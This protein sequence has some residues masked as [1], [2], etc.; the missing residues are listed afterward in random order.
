MWALVVLAIYLTPFFLLDWA[1]DAAMKRYA[2]D[3]VQSQAGA[4]RTPRKV[5][6]ALAL[7][8][9]GLPLAAWTLSNSLKPIESII[10]EL[11]PEVLEAIRRQFGI[12]PR[13][14]STTISPFAPSQRSWSPLKIPNRLR[15]LH[16]DYQDTKK[17]FL[18]MIG[19]VFEHP[20]NFPI[21]GRRQHLRVARPLLSSEPFRPI[22][23]GSLGRVRTQIGSR[24]SSHP[25]GWSKGRHSRLL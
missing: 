8:D 13:R 14:H 16:P 23:P 3:H 12:P 18:L 1:I 22:E 17:I 15:C 20:D 7:A 21:A 2:V 4:N 6:L 11:P 5:F 9:V 25:L 10:L 24:R 19:A